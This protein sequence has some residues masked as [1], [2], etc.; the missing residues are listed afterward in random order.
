[1]FCSIVLLLLWFLLVFW[2][3]H[4]IINSYQVDKVQFIS[5]IKDIPV[6]EVRN[7]E[8]ALLCGNHMDAEA[9]LLAAG[10]IFRAIMLNVQL[11]NWDR[12]GPTL[13]VQS[14]ST[15]DYITGTGELLQSCSTFMSLGT[16]FIVHEHLDGSGAFWLTSCPHG[17]Y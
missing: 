9:I 8:M 5:N 6:K 4:F 10:L 1:M 14:C 11:Y 3:W 15:F 13:L 7:A 17:K 2:V 12:W 16:I